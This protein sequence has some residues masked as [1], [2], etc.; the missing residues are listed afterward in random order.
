MVTR[1]M[2]EGSPKEIAEKITQLVG[3]RHVRVMLMEEPDA[4]ESRRIS[5]EEFFRILEEIKA[6]AVS[7]PHVD[8]SREGIY[9]ERYR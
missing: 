4:G 6:D 1:R 5:D 8:D 7:V 2:I 3:E 9:D